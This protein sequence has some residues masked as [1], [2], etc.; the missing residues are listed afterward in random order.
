MTTEVIISCCLSA[1]E[2]VAVDWM[3]RNLY[4]TDSG[5][6][7]IEVSSLIGGSRSVLLEVDRTLGPPALLALD[8]MSG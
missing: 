7:V 6:H 4:W 2:D 5:R 1:P 8:P 3:G